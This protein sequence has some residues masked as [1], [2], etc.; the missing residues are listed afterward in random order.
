[1]CVCVF[2]CVCVCVPWCVCVYVCGVIFTQTLERAQTS[3][4]E[5]NA[6]LQHS[7][8]Q[9]ASQAAESEALLLRLR[10]EKENEE[11]KAEEVKADEQLQ[12]QLE[13]R[14]REPEASEQELQECRLQMLELSRTNGQQANRSR[15]T[16]HTLIKP[17]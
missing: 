6:A 14:T 7:Y 3:L 8:T 11:V 9:A 12:K 15:S 16:W 1:V 17:P 13:D 2:V 5:K 4:T 10:H